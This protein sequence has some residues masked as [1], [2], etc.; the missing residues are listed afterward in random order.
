MG[1]R[2]RKRNLTYLMAIMVGCLVIGSGLLY[3]RQTRIAIEGIILRE[4]V[5]R[6]QAGTAPQERQRVNP[7]TADMAE[8][9]DLMIQLPAAWKTRWV[10]AGYL[11]RKSG[12]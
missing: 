3:V 5:R 11:D 2:Q 12:G 4:F 6:Q 1:E 8:L 9:G 7:L 10:V